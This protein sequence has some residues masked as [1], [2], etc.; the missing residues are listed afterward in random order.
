MK[1]ALLIVGSPKMERSTS[2]SIIEYLGTQ[3]VEYGMNIERMFTHRV[4]DASSLESLVSSVDSSDLVFLSAPLYVDSLPAPVI[5]VLQSITSHRTQCPES[6]KPLFGVVINSGFP[7]AHQ[8]D[9]A[10]EIC[11]LFAKRANLRWAGGIAFGGGG[12]ISG[13]PVDH[14]QY[15]NRFLKPALDMTAVAL[16]KGEPIPQDAIRL[17]AKPFVSIRMYYII[18]SRGWKRAARHSGVEKALGARPLE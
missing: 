3:L 2:N 11:H 16:F 1:N 7:E 17:A 9:C 13:V 15:V 8:S 10:I 14:A 4:D 12:A 6:T 5:R 18:A